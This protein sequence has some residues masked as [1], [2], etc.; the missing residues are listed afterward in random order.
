MGVQMS[1]LPL[2]SVV[3]VA[4]PS[5]GVVRDSSEASPVR[6]EPPAP[7][8]QAA[9]PGNPL[10]VAAQALNEALAGK[11]QVN[12]RLSIERDESSNRYVFKSINRDTGEVIR[13]YPTEQMLSQIARVRQI[14]GLTVD[15]GA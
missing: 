2:Q 5:A 6:N 3:A 11:L 14:A 15:T 9:A 8:Q 10:E 12:S 13:Q 4:R 7:E 1:V